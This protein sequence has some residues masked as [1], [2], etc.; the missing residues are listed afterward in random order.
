M[1]MSRLHRVVREVSADAVD[2][3]DLYGTVRRVSLLAFDG[4]ALNA[5]DWIVVH[6]GYALSR[7]DPLEAGDIAFEIRRAKL[8]PRDGLKSG[9]RR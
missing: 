8:S 5:G 7:V 6:S 3:E 1:C 4:S 9:V 2:V